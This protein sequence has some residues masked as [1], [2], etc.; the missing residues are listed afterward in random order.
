[1]LQS[2]SWQEF[3]T[4]VGLL[5]AAYYFVSTIAFYRSEFVNRFKGSSSKID[6]KTE[7]S[8]NDS[9]LGAVKAQSP[10]SV[11]SDEMQFQAGSPDEEILTTS[12]QSDTILLI[13]TIAAS[14]ARSESFGR[15]CSGQFQRRSGD[16]F[17]VA[18]GTIHQSSRHALPIE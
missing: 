7:Q 10:K 1:M 4:A 14:A 9:M 13:G 12:N 3:S 2:I 15:S 16:F 5:V 17:Q 6:V 11:D 8:D 18:A